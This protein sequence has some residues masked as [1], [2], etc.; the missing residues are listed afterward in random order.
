MTSTDTVI[1]NQ[2]T[3]IAHKQREQQLDHIWHLINQRAAQKA[4]HECKLFTQKYEDYDH[5]W[6]AFSFLL[7]QLKKAGEA[8]HCIEKA[9]NISPQM[10][11]WRIHKAHVL[12]LLNRLTD[13]RNELSHIK[14]LP[15][16]MHQ[17][18]E[19]AE[20]SN[21]LSDYHVAQN[22]YLAMLNTE[23]NPQSR[24]QLYFN[25]GS[26]QRYLGDL[27]AAEQSLDEALALSPNDTEALLL[28][29]SLRKQTLENNHTEQLQSM[30]N[31]QA[32][33]AL[34]K[35][36][37]CYS[38]AKEF[39]DLQEY[40]ASFKSLKIG[41]D[42]RRQSIRYDVNNDIRALA[43]IRNAFD[44]QYFDRLKQQSRQ[45][46]SASDKDRAQIA[47]PI[48]IF[49]LPRTGS[50]LVE[51]IISNHSDVTSAG[52]LNYFS[53][54]L[55]Q[56]I[57]E[58]LNIKPSDQLQSIRS[59]R[60][61][62]PE[63]LGQAYLQSTRSYWQQK[64]YFIDKLPL[65]SLNAGL[66]KGAIPNAKMILVQRNPMDTCYAIYKH[67]FTQG[68]PFSYSL[69]ELG[70]YYVAHHQLMQHWVDTLGSDL[71]TVRYEALVSDPQHQTQEM[72]SYLDLQF[73]PSC[74]Q[75]QNNRQASTTASA[76]QVRQGLYRDSV[77]KWR[78][79]ESQLAPLKKRL[80]DAGI[81]I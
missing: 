13:G 40:S 26:V 8:L 37:V 69:D 66:I 16:T 33:N 2:A 43:E 32:L 74:L 7:F 77:E 4:L 12:W 18:I 6:Y 61:L 56:Q 73:E 76:S 71:Y 3:V 59:S 22:C 72:L 39:E 47:T 27:S 60:E 63:K 1:N 19:L 52:E 25:L 35:S 29:S 49:G 14:T 55:M 20:V 10:V 51:R 30:L 65:N 42:S 50:T 21:K 80:E 17:L 64:P 41:A 5:G 70:Q 81:E 24:A 54:H 53:W 67:L 79:F 34:Q 38:L 9:V 68:Y 23:K 58:Q 45:S 11:D 28:R 78:H 36:Q 75:F 15:Q 31:T 46:A 44:Q 48:F 62:A 57:S